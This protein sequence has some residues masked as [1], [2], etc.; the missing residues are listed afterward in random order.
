MKQSKTVFS[1]II[2]SIAA[3]RAKLLP[4]YSFFGEDYYFDKIKLFVPEIDLYYNSAKAQIYQIIKTKNLPHLKSYY[5]LLKRDPDEVAFLKKNLTLMGSHFFRGK[6]WDT[7]ANECLT[8]FIGRSKVRVWCAGCS[9]GEEVYSIIME[10]LDFVPIE[11]IEVL[12]TDYNPDM[13]ERCRTGKYG[14]THYQE[15]PEKYQKYL[16]MI[17]SSFTFIPEIKD[18]ITTQ[19]LNLLSDEYPKEFDL[20]I[21]RNVIKFFTPETVKEVQ[22]KLINSLAPDGFLFLSVND[23]G[24]NQETIEDPKAFHV[25]QIGECIY[26]KL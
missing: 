21:C 4:G 13:L 10:L 8:R 18:T 12:A 23:E 20:I 6:G 3:L 9:S 17:K 1:S 25:K 15:I 11:S 22:K 16:I 5:Q 7:L 2:N 26:Q 14:P 19:H 24:I